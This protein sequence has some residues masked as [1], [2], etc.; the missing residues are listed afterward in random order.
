MISISIPGAKELQL[1]YLVLDFNGTLGVD[2]KLL[3]GVKDKLNILVSS[4][5]IHIVSA[6]TF[7]NVKEQLK[8]VKCKIKITDETDQQLQKLGYIAQLGVD[9]VVAVGNGRNDALMLKHAALGICL[10]QK[11]GASPETMMGADVVCNNI[12]DALDLLTNPLRL[13]ATLR[14]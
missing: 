2:G 4:L 6:D 14:K 9:S 5:D 8:H 1:Q 13:K 12:F 7:G 10:I 3:E 11:E